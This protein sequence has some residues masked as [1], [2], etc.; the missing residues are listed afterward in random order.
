[1]DD[2]DSIPGRNDSPRNI[3]SYPVRTGISPSR[4]K[5]PKGEA[6]Q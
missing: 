5:G 6:E 4:E 2:R 3:F 1:M